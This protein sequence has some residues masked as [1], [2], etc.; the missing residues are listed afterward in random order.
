MKLAKSGLGAFTHR[1]LLG[2]CGPAAESATGNVTLTKLHAYLFNNLSEQHRPQ[3]FGQQ[4]SPFILVGNPVPATASEAQLSPSPS[5]SGSPVGQGKSPEPSKGGGLLKKYAPASSSAAMSVSASQAASAPTESSQHPQ[6]DRRD[7]ENLV[8]PA[9]APDTDN[10]NR[11]TPKTLN[12]LTLGQASSPNGLL[13]KAVPDEQQSN[14]NKFWNKHN[15]RCKTR[16]IK[17]LLIWLNKFC[18]MVPNDIA[19][20][21]LKGQLLGT[22]GRLA[23]ATATVEQILQNDPNNALAWSMRAVLL[24]NMGQKQAAL[25]AIER[26]LEIDASNPESYGIKTRI[27]ENLATTRTYNGAQASGI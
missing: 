19:A 11:T 25:S 27:M 16:T 10:S 4:T 9:I 3:L 17:R 24:S 13:Q 12:G 26:S 8:P 6:T 21:T 14:T 20:L 15:N 18:S 22:A 5:Q 7:R 1:L 23:D 2:L